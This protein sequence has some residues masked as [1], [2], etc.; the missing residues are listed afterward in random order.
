M[1]L[2]RKLLIV[3]TFIAGVF[4]TPAV[5]STANAL[6]KVEKPV[7]SARNRSAVRTTQGGNKH[8]CKLLV[9]VESPTSS[10]TGMPSLTLTLRN[11]SRSAIYIVERA[12]SKDFKFEIK[13]ASG[14]IVL[15]KQGLVPV[16][17]GK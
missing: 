7:M 1:R 17:K 5:S 10:S 6:R 13:D 9:R 3:A 16:L 11:E 14:K 15:P 12:P 8:K 2:D 4:I